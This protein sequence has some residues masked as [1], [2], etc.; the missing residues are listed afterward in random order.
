MN[1]FDSSDI[2][3]LKKIIKNYDDLKKQM[4]LHNIT[5]DQMLTDQ[6]IQWAITTPLYNIGEHTNNL[7]KVFT[8]QYQDIPRNR[9]A[10]LRHR[11]VHHYEGTNWNI[12]VEVIFDDLPK[13]IQQLQNI[14]E[15]NS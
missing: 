6:F 7:S 15:E 12:I 11:L 2:E 14:I 13:Y 4:V 8:E 5:K 3:R 10:G 1:K 9:I